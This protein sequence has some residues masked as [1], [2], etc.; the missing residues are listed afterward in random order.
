MSITIQNKTKKKQE[1]KEEVLFQRWLEE[2]KIPFKKQIT[3]QIPLLT[4][5]YNRPKTYDADIYLPQCKAIISLEGWAHGIYV[6]SWKKDIVTKNH[7][8][9][10]GY[11]IYTLA[12]HEVRTIIAKGHEWE[13]H[14]FWLRD[15][16]LEAKE[17]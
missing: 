12:N 3:F 8:Q 16:L 4:S 15:L 14:M 17:R 2:Q 6:D 7:F 9:H 5:F 11:R 1:S 13:P 10:Q